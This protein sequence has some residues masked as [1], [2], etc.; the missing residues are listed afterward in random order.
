MYE[1]TAT[2]NVK[3]NN[4]L[5]A[6][7]HPMYG[8]GASGGAWFLSADNTKAVAVVSGGAPDHVFGAGFTDQTAAMIGY[9]KNGCQ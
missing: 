4:A 9:V 5:N 3:A 2:I 1:E 8:G 6:V 7:P